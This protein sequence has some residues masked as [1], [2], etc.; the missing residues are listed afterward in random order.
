MLLNELIYKISLHFRLLQ[1]NCP[2]SS[3]VVEQAQHFAEWLSSH[4]A[5]D[6]GRVSL[7]YVV[8]D[9][10]RLRST[11]MMILR[12]IS[13]NVDDGTYGRNTICFHSIA[14]LYIDDYAYSGKLST[15]PASIARTQATYQRPIFK[16]SPTPLYLCSD[17]LPCCKTAKHNIT[18]ST[19]LSWRPDLCD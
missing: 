7:E 1:G 16:A 14:A 4:R 2:S 17:F 18:S 10:Q 15:Q 5:D 6:R 12:E 11:L 9:S 3:R 19:T 13:E 8:R